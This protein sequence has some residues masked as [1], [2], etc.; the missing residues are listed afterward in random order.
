MKKFEAPEAKVT[1]LEFINIA[2]TSND[3]IPP[4]TGD[5][6]TPYG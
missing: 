5:N 1:V 6:Q 3:F 4:A 2:A